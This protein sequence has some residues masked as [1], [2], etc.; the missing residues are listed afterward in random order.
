MPRVWLPLILLLLATPMRAADGAGVIAATIENAQIRGAATFRWLG[1]PLYTAR[2]FTPGGAAVDWSRPVALQL[3]YARDIKRQSLV[4]ATVS[5]LERLEGSQADHAVIGQKLSPC[6]RNVSEG[7]QFVAATRGRDE[8]VL[9]FNGNKTGST[10]HD[11]LGRRF[12]DIWLSD[13]SRSPS[14]S[15]KL[16][17]G[18]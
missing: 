15:R 16:R 2:L 6:F 7:D 10:S 12:L 14:Q 13:N 5:E 11:N 17:G 18:T 8:V 3:T 4:D 1:L 9:F